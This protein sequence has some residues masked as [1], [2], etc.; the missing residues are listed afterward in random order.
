MHQNFL[1]PTFLSLRSFPQPLAS[2]VQQSLM[3]RVGFVRDSTLP[4]RLG[5]V[6]L[7]VL[8]AL[9]PLIQALVPP[10]GE[11]KIQVHEVCDTSRVS[12]VFFL[13]VA[14]RPNARPPVLTLS[15]AQRHLDGQVLDSPIFL[16]T[17]NKVR[18]VAWK[19]D[20]HWITMQSCQI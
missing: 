19:P 20:L 6:C 1:A 8:L 12:S 9:L 17:N 2:L 16:G 18:N 5:S 3:L 13:N 7:L 10:C 14:L 15:L 11:L 4:L